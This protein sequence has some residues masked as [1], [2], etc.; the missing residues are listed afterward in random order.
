MASHP[1][2]DERCPQRLGLLWAHRSRHSASCRPVDAPGT[3]P[4]RL[5]VSP[6]LTSAP[7]TSSSMASE[8]RTLLR[9]LAMCNS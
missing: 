7:D 9:T 6:I 8:G 4:I 2:V 5:L 3:N 1:N